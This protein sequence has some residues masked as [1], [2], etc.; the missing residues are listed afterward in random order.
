MLIDKP[1]LIILSTVPMAMV[2]NLLL[3]N[4]F[5]GNQSKALQQHNS[6]SATTEL[7]ENNTTSSTNSAM[8]FSRTNKRLKVSHFP[9]PPAH[10]FAGNEYSEMNE[11]NENINNQGVIIK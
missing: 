10:T 4:H 7:K 1:R 5:F 11:E 2:I 6:Y 3:L 8:V 9:P